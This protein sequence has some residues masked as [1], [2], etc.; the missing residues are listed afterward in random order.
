MV[1]GAVE[2]NV[3][4]LR[5]SGYASPGMFVTFTEGGG[6]IGTSVADN[7]GYF[8][9]IFP[10]IAPADHTI[11]IYGVDQLAR[12]T[13]SALVEV[14]TRAYQ[15]TTVTGIILPPT[16]EID[17]TEITRGED[18]TVFGRGTPGYLI[19]VTTEPP[20]NSFENIVDENGDFSF[21]ISETDNME[22]GDHKVYAL[23]QDGLGT[24]S[25]FSVTLFFRVLDSEPPEGNEPDCNITRGDLNCDDSVDLVDFSILMYYW[26]T[27]NGLADINYDGNVNLV[28]FSI[29][30]FYWQG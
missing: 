15:M 5:I 25:L 1:T 20:V 8:T 29:M 14:Y 13:P 7:S 23:V 21:T 9:Q 3:G 30:M 10:G 26:G 28:D 2:A 6:T 16:L 27:N 4:T 22:F 17:K 19:K 12:T 11:L 24:Q 18:I